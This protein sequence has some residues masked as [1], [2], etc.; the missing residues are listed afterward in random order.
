ML[1]MLR[2]GGK[3]ITRLYH[4]MSIDRFM[5]AKPEVLLKANTVPSCFCKGK[6]V[7]EAMK[8]D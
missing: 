6:Y 8:K 3:L 2:R 7:L 4:Y 1:S 5:R